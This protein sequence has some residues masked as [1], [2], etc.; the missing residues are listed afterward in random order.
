MKTTAFSLMDTV[1]ITDNLTAFA[2]IRADFFDY[3]L[4]VINSTTLVRT[5]YR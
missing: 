2:G 4:D 3:S 5:P 1:S